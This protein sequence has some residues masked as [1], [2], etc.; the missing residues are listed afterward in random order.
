MNLVSDMT[1]PHS[2]THTHTL[3]LPSLVIIIFTQL[4]ILQLTYAQNILEYWGFFVM[5]FSPEFKQLVAVESEKIVVSTTEVVSKIVAAESQKICEV[6][7]ESNKEILKCLLQKLSTRADQS[8]PTSHSVRSTEDSFST[9]VRKLINSSISND[10]V[11]LVSKST[12]TPFLSSSPQTSSE[13]LHSPEQVYMNYPKL[14][15]LNKIGT[16]ASKLSREAYFGTTLMS[17]CT[18]Y[19][20]RPA[21]PLQKVKALKSFLITSFKFNKSALEFEPYWKYCV[22]A[23]NHS[24]NFIR[25]QKSMTQDSQPPICDIKFEPCMEDDCYEL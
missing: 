22:D 7:L 12:E 1:P 5:F 9:P 23:I 16:L 17:R 6:L 18:V 13:Q 20:T 14:H 10:D 11:M 3:P 25:K 24:C 19:G 15:V 4:T 21:L 8:T 2:L